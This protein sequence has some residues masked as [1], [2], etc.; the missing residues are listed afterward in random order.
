MS[1]EAATPFDDGHCFACGPKSEIGLRLRFEQQPDGSVRGGVTLGQPYQG[2]R[3]VAH[4]G[5]VA[6]LLDE[7]MAH[8][9][10]VRGY[11]GMTGELKLRFRKAVPIGAPLVLRGEVLWQRRSVLGLAA[12]VALEDGSELA[13]GEGSFVVKGRLAPGRRLGE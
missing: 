12:T 6:T 2:W 10:G 13:A 3:G 7:A 4:G 11:L 1:L 9:A 8:A 5:I